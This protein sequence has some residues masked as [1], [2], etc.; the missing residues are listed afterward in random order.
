M[1]LLVANRGEIALRVVRAAQER[2]IP[3]VGVF[4]AD[5]AGAAH[6]RLADEAVAL[7]GD[8]PA[9]YRDAA[10]LVAAGV[11]TGCTH[12]HP[13]YGFLSEDPA[14]ARACAA[15]GL[16]FVGP[17]PEVLEVFG[18]K[19]AARDAAVTAGVPVVEA[20][21]GTASL[22]TVAAFLAEHPDGV[23]LK[24]QSAGGGR[25]LRIVRDAAELPAAHA[26]CLAEAAAVSGSAAL[27]AEELVP[28]ARHIEVQVLGV[29]DAP[30]V[31]DSGRVRVVALG[32]RDCSVQRGMQKLIEQAP[33]PELPDDLRFDLHA[34]AVTLCCAA[35][36]VGLA[37]VE[38][39]VAGDRYVFCEVNPR[40]QVEHTVTE[41]V[42]GLDLVGL[43]LAVAAGARYDDLELPPGVT[44]R[45]GHPPQ[46]RVADAIGIA[47]QVRLNAETVDAAG[48]V[49]AGT[50]TVTAFTPPT[51]TGVRVETHV[52]PGTEITGRYDSLLAKLVTH[53]R[54]T[55]PDAARARARAALL[56]T[57]LRGVP[58]N[59]ALLLAVLDDRDFAAGPV[60]T[61]WLPAALPRLLARAA[62]L[63]D[64]APAAAAARAP[65]PDPE[66]A[67]EP[68]ETA[69]RVELPG[70]VV[71]VA[72]PGTVV[73]AGGEL[74]V[75][76]A[77]KM[78][79]AVPAPAVV[80]VTR[81]FA[82]PG[83]V[84]AAG[85][86]LLATRPAEAAAEVVAGD[87]LPLEAIRD[88]LAEVLARHHRTTDEA[89]ADRLQK[90]RDRGRRTARENLA[91][92]VDPGSFVEYGALALA[93][94]R[95]RRSVEELLDTT[96]ADGL[97]G[98]TATVN[99]GLVDGPGDAVVMSY[100]Y[101][102]LA[103]TQGMV[104]HDKTDRLL[105]LAAR[106]R[107][108]VVMFPEGGG[109]RPGD[110]DRVTTALGVPTFRRLAEL[111]G[112]VPLVAV[113]SGRCFA[114]NAA[115]AGTCDVI[116]ATPDANLGM[117]GP[118]M[119][120][121]GGLGV[122]APEDIGPIDVQTRNGVVDVLAADEAEAVGLARKYLAFFQGRTPEGKAPDP[123]LARH[124]VPAD[125]LR[126][127]DVRAAIAALVDAD[128]E[129]ELRPRY[130][131]GIVTAL[132]RV[133]GHPLAVLANDSRVL[134]GA[135]DAEAAQKAREFLRLA[136]DF[137]LPVLSLCDTPGFMVGPAAEEQA[138]VRRFAELFAAGAELQVPIGMIVLRK[139]YGLGAMAMAMG[140]L[141]T[142][143]FTVAWPTGELGP[144]G[145]E[146]A[147]R[148]GFRRE[149]EAAADEAERQALYD[150]LVALAYEHGKALNAATLAEIDDV[151]DPADSRRW[152]AQLFGR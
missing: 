73:P 97:V 66:P 10:A 131:R 118:A 70:T 125:R 106:R 110:T 108:P 17:S 47:L 56:E 38:F 24:A 42:T 112:K 15:A 65:A 152:I 95:Q 98:G 71:A 111:R 138:S 117:G 85:A 16:V 37:T 130:G 119:I 105:E 116:I 30:A 7:P 92:L 32:D 143:Q 137:G 91:D 134:G 150:G 50:G 45:T 1:K 6:A 63:A 103:G 5:E 96:P 58:T 141:Q 127:Y 2:S 77:M 83:R 13:G 99:A 122:V 102:V 72:A 133:E 14:F 67:L 151:I 34:A 41:E 74:A 120:E 107:L 81:V 25:G 44:A 22:E 62:E 9:A 27:F 76:E 46:G 53:V 104:N 28:E 18:D 79:H 49:A 61:Q 123:R 8:G 147:V 75:L 57:D 78:Q 40:L 68:G 39:L 87:G 84:L 55:L 135:I 64:D 43:S 20:T 139:G 144:M 114:G 26:R 115:L 36:L 146:G 101:T 31:A 126:S 52:R 3:T 128:S 12:V 140:H 11:D 94:Q 82:A 29:P 86:V 19:V 109:G 89:R 93:A 69:I 136:R 51:G 100:D 23:M 121:G 80:E 88:D 129:L 113:V 21:D 48:R 124:V 145:L 54:S 149:L 90:L 4:A 148:L 59:R 33:A 132:A 60:T 142:P 35:R